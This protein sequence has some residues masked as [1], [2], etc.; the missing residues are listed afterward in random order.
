MVQLYRFYGARLRAAVVSLS[1]VVA[2]AVGV[3]AAAP[4]AHADSAPPAG[5]PATVTADALPT[6]QQNGVIWAEV[7]VGN[8]VYAAGSFSQTWP[9][10][11]TNTSA[12]DTPR[13]NLLAF[14]IRTG[15]LTSFNHVLNAQA[16]AITASSDGSRVYVAGDF[17]TVD[18]A[19]HNHIA[20]FDT[21]T[22]ALVTSFTA[23]ISNT[24]NAL[25]INSAGSVIYAGG[26]FFNVNG[27]ARTRLAAITSG[28]A[29]TTWAPTADDNIVTALVVTPD[30]SEVVIGGRFLSLDGQTTY[31]LG[32]V[33]TSTG[34]WVSYAANQYIQDYTDANSAPGN[35]AGIESLYTDGTQVYGSGYSFNEGNFEGT[36]GLDPD[37]GTINIV[38]DCHGDTYGVFAT[39]Q[40]LYEVS[41][42]HDC[43][44][45]GDF[46]DTDP[47]IWHHSTAFTTYPTG[48]NSGPDSYGWNFNG[49]P[50][51]T[52]LQWYPAFGLG[53]YTGQSQSAWSV[54]GN[55]QYIAL[56]GEF[57][58]VNGGAQQG[59]VRF[60]IS[61]IAPNKVGPTP[62][63]TLTPSAL[64]LSAGT[65]RVSWQS[66]WDEDNANLT[67]NVLRDG[68][69]TPV[70]TTT[71]TSNF[72]QLPTIGF[73]DTGLTPGS[74]HTYRIQVVD[75]SGNKIGSSTSAPVTISS[76]TTTNPYL[77][78]VTSDGSSSLWRF[79]ETSG[80]KAYDWV[81]FNDMSEG[82]GVTDAAQTGPL[83]GDT[84]KAAAFNG[85]SNGSASTS[86]AIQGPNTFAIEGWFQTSTRSGGKIVGFGNT[87]QGNLSG[88]Y[89]RQIYMDNS[90]HLIFGVYNNGAYT[91]TSSK[92]Y[93]NSKWH[94]V[95]G[96]LS[97]S[98]MSMYVD[99][100]LV[101][102][103]QGTTVGQDYSGY[104]RVG[105]DNL[106]SWPSQPSSNWFNGSI[107]DVAVYPSTLTIRQVQQHYTDAGGQLTIQ[108]VPTDAYGQAVYNSN[109]LL[110]W[111]LNDASHASSALDTSPYQ[112]NG[113][114]NSGVT[115][116]QSS[117][118]ST[119]GKAAKFNGSTG[120]IASTQTFTDPT[121]YSEEL[122]FNTT[123]TDGGKLIGFG[124]Q[125]TGLSGNYDRHVYMLNTGQL[126]F[127]TYTGV[128]NTIV[129]PNSYN[130]GKWH[131]LVATQG[132]AGMALYVD[133]QLLGTNPQTQAQNYTGY[134]RVGG[135]PT[136]GG[137]NSNYFAG[138]IDE[139]A[140][141][142]TQLTPAQVLAHYEA[143]PAAV[144]PPPTA[145]IGTP[146]CTNLACSFD[147]SGSTDP[148]GTITGY[149]WTFGD[150]GTATTAT[151]SHTYTAGGTYPVALTVT[152]S[153]GNT[154]TTHTSV[155][156][157]PP[158][159]PV[160]AIAT[161]NCTYLAC[162]FDGSGSTAPS[163]IITGYGWDF[164]DG[165]T[166]S[167]AT[168][169]HAF[170][171]AGSY[172]VTLTVTD[173]NGATSVASVTVT[174]TA[175]PAPTA[176]IA[177]PV[178]TFLACAF[179]GTSSAAA[180][181][182]ITGYSW[183][184]GDGGTATTAT[185]SHAYGSP[186]TYTVKLTVT[187]SNGATGAANTTVTVTGPP[188]PTA[189]IAT[190]ACTF[191]ACTF[192]GTGS[193]TAS[194]TITGYSWDFGDGGTAT[195]AAPSHTYGSP[196][197]YTVK[198][199]VTDSNGN[200]GSASTSLTVQGTPA[201]PVA[202]FTSSCPSLTCGFDGTST[203][204][205]SGAP[206]STYAWTFG[207]GDTGSG[208]TPSEAYSAAGAYPVT[209]TVTDTNGLTS[210][211][212]HT[213]SPAPSGNPVITPYAS[214][215]YGRTVGTG[216]GNADSGGAWTPSGSASSLSVSG[217]VGSIKMA[218]PG[219]GPGAYLGGISSTD[220]STLA[221]VTTTA[222]PS[223]S[224][225]Y[226]D[227]VGRRI[228]SNTDYRGRVIVGANGSVV[229]SLFAINGGTAV[230]L[231]AKTL[232]GFTYTPGMQLNVQLQ[233][234]GTSPTSLGMKV[235]PTT[236]PQPTSWQVSATDSTGAL[237][238]PGAVGLAAFLPSNA[239][240][241][242]V[243]EQ[244]TSFTSWPSVG[245]PNAAFAVNCSGQT[246]STDASNSTDPS[247]TISSYT[248]GWGD[249]RVTTGATSSHT[250]AA[251]GTYT[252]TLTVTN[253]SGWTSVVT[254]NVTVP[255]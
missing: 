43:S 23:S 118:V 99:G 65:A 239:T 55:S 211:V 221:I 49:L 131:H 11:T 228:S 142:D 27:V 216:W 181:G 93:N 167:S 179:D 233:V 53:T 193:S 176:L 139:V 115:F 31:G 144:N 231:K 75:P 61:S 232:T 250:Y 25:A 212:T 246:C 133:G 220:T 201:A 186:G 18:G 40:V 37:S 194:G 5:T 112:D 217:G 77:T 123:T 45:M 238:A 128:T 105:G 47:R 90:G 6:V 249:G 67:Y 205:P 214:D 197:T 36:F 70:Y 226:L 252:V 243:T 82:S 237:Q 84:A 19:T 9:A 225:T 182:P 160:A 34:S 80:S 215:G 230:T 33:T 120:L 54:T 159:P 73:V 163:G 164:G 46:P 152:D 85:T 190:P 95:V 20:A 145:L 162:A 141:Y 38:N 178:C 86:T 7:T 183:D 1:L 135:D 143:S 98:G 188:A 146:G 74:T 87:T 107:A 155:T 184:F 48:T 236:A 153:F 76:S 245:L 91:V 28:G 14:D 202:G 219:A 240:T 96:E 81:G 191:R 247:G 78:D 129:S 223:G 234:T 125:P 13:A 30:Q 218:A 104:W 177:T 63:S 140:V 103:N 200:S 4:A 3:V 175:P 121:V 29:L 149:S 101:G 171:A 114:A 169:N 227:V 154:N 222:A 117:P 172:P 174:V 156:V 69:T 39:G 165:G 79:N 109:P 44:A 100:A 147:G 138:T 8:T 229:I 51:S 170:A 207:N 97:S 150:G 213:V 151:P 58:T 180:S 21:A 35:G 15:Q 235:W 94:Y 195:T 92:T 244:V 41:H 134:W 136:W 57:P 83:A 59:I 10:G 26:N 187:D 173:S 189:V 241:S 124:D 68:G 208:A 203:A 130:N 119:T 66:T 196:G 22:G 110:Y 157:T 2:A 52:L 62:S 161:P 88:S 113:S 50:D 148:N 206:I 198:L 168:P 251:A 224:G 17:T 242:P 12:N 64:S 108:P 42:E 72:W 60:A 199:T 106:G 253:P 127:G 137:A 166:S 158:Q 89:D 209:L 210:S 132:P 116:Q 192:D 254:R 126:E 71:L 56:G 122:W 32:A 204:T 255:A 16:L 248:W 111:R 102:Q 185:P 24:V